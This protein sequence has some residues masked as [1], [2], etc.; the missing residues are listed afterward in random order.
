[1]DPVT[2][3][4]GISVELRTWQLWLRHGMDLGGYGCGAIPLMTRRIR[5]LLVAPLCESSLS[6]SLSLSLHMVLHS[7]MDLDGQRLVAV[8]VAARQLGS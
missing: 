6:L 5:R 7:G 2:K 8:R 4:A 1:M 3:H